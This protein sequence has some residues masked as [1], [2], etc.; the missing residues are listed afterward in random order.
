MRKLLKGFESDISKSIDDARAQ[1]WE[2]AYQVD[3]KSDDYTMAR[4]RVRAERTEDKTLRKEALAA[5]L[6]KDA[7]YRF[8]QM[9]TAAANKA[10]LD[11][12]A[13]AIDDRPRLADRAEGGAEA[14][15][16]AGAKAA[17]EVKATAEAKAEAEA[18]AAAEAKAEVEAEAKTAAEAKVAAE[19]KAEPAKGPERPIS[20]SEGS[21]DSAPPA[22]VEPPGEDVEG[23]I[24]FV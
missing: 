21:S 13:K 11:V 2:R 16:A 20:G 8:T 19:A 17:A 6:A 4:A 22:S 14:K 10:A 1:G 9:R 15:A 18:K 23:P 12:L 7:D 3:P 5:Q 24:Q